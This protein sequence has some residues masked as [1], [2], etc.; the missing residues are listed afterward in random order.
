MQVAR[1]FA[2]LGP[3]IVVLCVMLS[4]PIMHV[5]NAI[6]DPHLLT[7]FKLFQVRTHSEGHCI[8]L[9][10]LRT[11]SKV[12]DTAWKSGQDTLQRSK[13]THTHTTYMYKHTNIHTHTHTHTHTTMAVFVNT[14]GY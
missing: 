4:P 13:G 7:L 11:H 9:Q 1:G 10:Q 14:A 3:K 12:Q 8:R 5:C 2:T 6:C